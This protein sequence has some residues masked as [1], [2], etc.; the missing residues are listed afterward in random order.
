M[1]IYFKAEVNPFFSLIVFAVCAATLRTL[2]KLVDCSLSIGQLSL[3]L[4]EMAISLGALCS[5]E[6]N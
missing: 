1:I 6:E 5:Q 2:T 4:P 3:F